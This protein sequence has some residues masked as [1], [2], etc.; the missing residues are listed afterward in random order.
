LA[1]IETKTTGFA[2]KLG[3][4]F[5]GI[6]VGILFIIGATWMLYNN[7]GD[8]VYTGDA[9][10]EAQRVFVELP[11]I[12]RIDASFN[13][14]LV[15]ASGMAETKDT[16]TDDIFGV[17]TIAVKFQRKSEYYQW[18]ETA[19]TVTRKRQR[20]GQEQAAADTATYTYDQQWVSSPV[21]SGVFK[22][23][24]YQGKN[25]VLAVIPEETLGAPEVSFGAY[26]LPPFL[27][28]SIS[29]DIPLN[30]QLTEQKIAELTGTLVG[31]QAGIHVQANTIYIGVSPSSP[32]IGD[33]RVSF[34]EVRPAKVSIVAVV[35]GNTFEE[36]MASSGKTFSAFSMGSV[37]ADSMFA[38]AQSNIA[39]M[40]WMKRALGLLL[41]FA[42]LKLVM[43]PLFVLASALPLLGDIVGAG[44]SVT[45]FLLGL[46]WSLLVISI[47]WLHFRPLIGGALVLT[48]LV[49]IALLYAKGRNRKRAEASA[50]I[51]TASML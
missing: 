1:S 17:Q 47:A 7:E 5:G 20:G 33:V 19:Q 6:G 45:A 36:Y 4:S 29:G 12:T 38:G 44:T 27:K 51:Q 11:D 50:A 30:V 16:L 23:S 8:Y 24:Q 22:D 32:N 41:V 42:G 26:T 49:L 9:I 37:G 28:D 15:H 39:A 14:R 40:T 10:T 2:Q 25:S 35:A 21:D 48:A 34:T 31:A 13:G 43:R 18:T 3:S 46:A